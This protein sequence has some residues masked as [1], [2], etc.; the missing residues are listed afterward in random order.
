[1]SA[2]KVSEL[3]SEIAAS[4]NVADIDNKIEQLKVELGDR[5]DLG[6]LGTALEMRNAALEFEN[7]IENA[8]ATDKTNV[9]LQ[10][11]FGLKCNFKA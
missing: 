2:S 11:K 9:E 1:M 10:K 3:C 7:T 8:N 6:L 4:R 5:D